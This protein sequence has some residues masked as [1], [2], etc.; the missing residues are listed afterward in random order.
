MRTKHHC[1]V[2]FFVCL[3]VLNNLM[4]GASSSGARVVVKEA[5]SMELNGQYR[6]QDPL[7]ISSGFAATCK[8]M[9][10]NTNDMWDR[11]TDK[12]T[13]WYEKEDGAYIYFNRGDGKW[14][15]DN[16][17]GGGMYIV[18]S[19]MDG[20]SNVPPESGYK[21]LPGA[22]HPAPTVFYEHSDANLLNL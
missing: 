2:L 8:Q 17:D 7:A 6:E 21:I 9:G 22:K 11:L 13:P 12:K 20:P 4:A 16:K 18:Q 15:I 5:G 14:W 1:H 10:W 19:K 3:C